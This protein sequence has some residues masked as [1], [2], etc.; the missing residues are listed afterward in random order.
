MAIFNGFN[1]KASAMRAIKK[2]GF[3]FTSALGATESNP[4]LAKGGKLGVLTKAHN[5]APASES[6][7][8]MC[9]SASEGCKIACLHTAGNPVYLP[10]KIRA[11][12]NRTLA[13]MKCRSAY[14]ALL[15]FE[16]EAH[17]RRCKML[18]MVCAWRPN[19]TSDY[20]FHSVALVVN[21]VKYK[22]LIHYFNN[23]EAYDYTK[24]L[25]K[26]LQF[27]SPKPLLPHNYHITF[28][29]SESNQSDCIKLLEAGKISGKG[30]NVAIVFDRLPKD[31]KWKGFTV[32]D[33]DESDVRFLDLQGG[34]VIGLKAK[35]LGKR[36]LSGFVLSGSFANSEIEN[37][38]YEG[39]K[40]V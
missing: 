13:F 7:F 8:N 22:S 27:A 6:G 10:A 3:S 19:T 2:A 36:D 31:M 1:S 12:I 15:A 14:I 39:G 17:E 26:A 5:L 11:R 16:L 29:R 30:G 25:K 18:N 40:L 34:N 20:P 28:S 35:G 33:G 21:G 38:T 32:L 23:I 24:I 9:A 4:K 37:F